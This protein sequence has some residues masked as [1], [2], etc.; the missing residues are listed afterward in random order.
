MKK[1][2][3][4]LLIGAIGIIILVIIVNYGFLNN[5]I[6]VTRYNIHSDKI[7]NADNSAEIKIVQLTDVHSIRS[8]RQKD[9]LIGKIKAEEPDLIFIAGDLIDA[10]HYTEQDSL[11]Q[12]GK[13]TQIE[14]LTVQFMSELTDITE[15]YYVYGNHEIQ[16]LDDPDNNPFKLDLENAGVHILNN[17]LETLTVKGCKLNLVG[18]QDPSTLYKDKK[19]AYF[20]SKEETVQ[21]VLDDLLADNASFNKETFTMLIAHR[22]EYFELFASYDIDL[23]FTGH[24]HGGVMI[25]PFI[26]SLYSRGE[27]LFPKYGAG[28]FNQDNFTMII[29]RGLAYPGI[30]LRIFDPPEIVVATLSN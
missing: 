4:K 11:Y 1:R 27:G 3:K 16:L 10:D 6:F 23:A 20:D 30:P 24:T 21:A 28:I 12:Q 9:R 7:V 13:I 15:V 18:M 5:M 8:E 19:Y 2:A 22:P 29:N 14:A 26:G 25:L 17:S